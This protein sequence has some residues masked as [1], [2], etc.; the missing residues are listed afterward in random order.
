[1]AQVSLWHYNSIRYEYY[2]TIDPYFYPLFTMALTFD[3]LTFDR[4]AS[5]CI[6][7]GHSPAS[8]Q[9]RSA[10]TATSR[11]PR[12]WTP[13]AVCWWPG[14]DSPWWKTNEESSV[15]FDV[16]GLFPA[17]SFSKW[18]RS[19][20]VTWP[21]NPTHSLPGSPHR[22]QWRRPQTLSVVVEVV[23]KTFSFSPLLVLQTSLKH[24]GK[25]NWYCCTILWY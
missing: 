22:K 16:L 24:V 9:P 20:T 6:L 7:W 17:P 13:P 14:L 3:G 1:M 12:R 2:I 15:K 10:A 4:T 23:V 18:R 25:L 21:P 8:Q 11:S 19:S 5:A